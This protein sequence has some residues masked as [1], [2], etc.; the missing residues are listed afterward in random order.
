MAI[1]I[2]NAAKSL[3]AARGLPSRSSRFLCLHMLREQQFV[4]A[5]GRKYVFA[6][7]QN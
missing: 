6:A 3:A 7:R 1:D 4:A 5:R 2:A